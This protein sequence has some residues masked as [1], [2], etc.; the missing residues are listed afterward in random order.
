MTDKDFAVMLATLLRPFCVRKWYWGER[1][2]GAKAI[3]QHVEYRRIRIVVRATLG[4]CTQ[5][6]LLSSVER[7]G[8]QHVIRAVP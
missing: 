8:R 7:L 5:F 3:D 1:R 2:L 6:R 4:G